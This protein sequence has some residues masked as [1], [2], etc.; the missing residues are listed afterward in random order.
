[1]TNIE[2]YTFDWCPYC[3]KAR[4]IF[5]ENNIKYRNYDAAHASIRQEMVTRSGRNTVPQIFIDNIH[6]G[7][8]NDLVTFIEKGGLKRIKRE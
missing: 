6:L 8:Y 1:M 5:D 4:K 3:I 2:I 7:G